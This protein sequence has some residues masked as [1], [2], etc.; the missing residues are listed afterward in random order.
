MTQLI[1]VLHYTG[2]QLDAGKQVDIIYISHAKLLERF[3]QYSITS[4]LHDWFRS[5]LQGSKEQVTVLGVT[6]RELPVTS[7]VTKGCLLGPILFLLFVDDLPNTVKLRHGEVPVTPV[8]SKSSRALIL[9]QTVMPCNLILT[10]ASVGPSHLGSYLIT[11]SVNASALNFR[12]YPFFP[13]YLL[14]ALVISCI[15]YLFI[16]FFNLGSTVIG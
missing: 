9:S 12:L 1:S 8:I 6:S 10:I 11:P 2:G 15:F 7:G 14:V 5:C 16:F 3:H 4:K 13:V